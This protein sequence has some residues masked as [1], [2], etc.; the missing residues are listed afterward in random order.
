MFHRYAAPD[1]FDHSSPSCLL[2]LGLDLSMQLFLA[3]LQGGSVQ[4]PLQTLYPKRM[5]KC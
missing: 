1:L 2:T 4:D 5:R 3:C